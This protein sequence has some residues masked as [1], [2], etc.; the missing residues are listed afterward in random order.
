ML[1][2]QD[3]LCHQDPTGKA[4]GSKEQPQFRQFLP[5]PSHTSCVFIPLCS[6]LRSHRVLQ[7]KSSL[8]YLELLNTQA[9]YFDSSPQA[10]CSQS[11][12]K[13]SSVPL[14]R[15]H[16]VFLSLAYRRFDLF[17]FTFTAFGAFVSSVTQ[18]N[19]PRGISGMVTGLLMFPR[20]KH[21]LLV[22]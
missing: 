17:R 1:P 11:T 10:Y 9:M 15:C 22:S 13:I 16:P 2:P 18:K 20:A 8:L 3:L 19:E 14:H 21:T 6:M 5:F 12:L 4:S 7:D